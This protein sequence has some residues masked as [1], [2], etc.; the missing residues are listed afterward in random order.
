MS[1][2]EAQA[3]AGVAVAGGGWWYPQGGSLDPAAL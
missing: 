3:A 1:S 2:T